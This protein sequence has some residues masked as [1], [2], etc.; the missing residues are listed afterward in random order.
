MLSRFFKNDES[1]KVVTSSAKWVGQNADGRRDP[2]WRLKGHAVEPFWRWVA[3]WAR[4]MRSPEDL[5]FDG[6]RFDL[7]EL[8][9]NEHMID[10]VNP[11]EGM[12]FNMVAIGLAE[13]RDEAR[14]TINE[15]C[16]RVASLVNDT[17][18]PAI[19]WCHLNAEGDLLEKLIPDCVQVAG[20]DSIEHKEKAVEDFIAGNVRVLVSKP[21]IFGWGLNLQHCAHMTFFP[22]H[23]YEAYYQAVRRCW[24]FGQE[25][26]VTVD[27]VT[28][29]GGHDVMSNLQRKSDQAAEMFAS[30][31][32]HMHESETIQRIE[33]ECINMEV[34]AW[35][36]GRQ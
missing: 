27:I 24:R 26:P 16:E 8:T 21:K 35:M 1:T 2:G 28:T 15:R 34:P 13:Q 7:P 29:P 22:T 23:S 25:R 18:E 30:L 36:S 12:L 19:A 32:R 9:V 20:G 33:Y 3:S 6:S 31:V 11:A 10:S 17:G 4:A 14:R 5:G